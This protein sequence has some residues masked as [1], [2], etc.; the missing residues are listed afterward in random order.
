MSSYTTPPTSNDGNPPFQRLETTS[1]M[2]DGIATWDSISHVNI[3]HRQG[4]NAPAVIFQRKEQKQEQRS[5]FELLLPQTSANQQEMFLCCRQKTT[6]RAK[7]FRFSYDPEKMHKRKNPSYIG[8]MVCPVD[9]PNLYEVLLQAGRHEV[10]IASIVIRTEIGKHH[11][12]VELLNQYL[13]LHEKGRPGRMMDGKYHRYIQPCLALS[14]SSSKRVVLEL[15]KPFSGLLEA[16][17]DAQ[18]AKYMIDFD[19]PLTI[20]LSFA[21]S[22]A[23]SFSKLESQ[24]LEKKQSSSS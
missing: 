22:C 15:T 18:N 20:F 12:A 2:P 13:N 10:K 17:D 6:G 1:E 9:N 21:I 24:E 14:V 5:Y 3:I 4:L 23:V 7:A 19:Y 16:G 8:S 11:V